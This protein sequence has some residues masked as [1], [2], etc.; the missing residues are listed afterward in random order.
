M[1]ALGASLP[2]Q[3][4]S[5]NDIAILTLWKLQEHAVFDRPTLIVPRQFQISRKMSQ[6]AAFTLEVAL[7]D[8]GPKWSER[9]SAGVMKDLL[10]ALKYIHEVLLGTP[11]AVAAPN[12]W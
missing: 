5:P 6:P 10:C 1:P 11:R 9:L 3:A 8:K 12:C 7:T 2:K 4:H